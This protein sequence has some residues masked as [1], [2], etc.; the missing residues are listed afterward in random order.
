MHVD[1]EKG[2]NNVYIQP[3]TMSRDIKPCKGKLPLIFSLRGRYW[4]NDG[5]KAGQHWELKLALLVPGEEIFTF[6][7]CLRRCCIAE[8]LELRLNN[9][10]KD[11]PTPWRSSWYPQII[12]IEIKGMIMC[13]HSRWCY[14]GVFHQLCCHNI[15]IKLRHNFINDGLV[16]IVSISCS[17]LTSVN[18][19]TY[20]GLSIK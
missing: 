18:V 13:S 1:K 7:G 16:S 6:N 4:K 5:G 12:F 14:V 19:L 10:S 17:F 9:F 2:R 8:D 11:I 3:C 20:L 15:I